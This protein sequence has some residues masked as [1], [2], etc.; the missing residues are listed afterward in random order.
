MGQVCLR[1][2]LCKKATIPLTNPYDPVAARFYIVLLHAGLA[3]RLCTISINV[4]SLCLVLLPVMYCPH[5]RLVKMA[6]L[7]MATKL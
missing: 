6:S 3:I 4:V 1:F 7:V 5:Y 2:L